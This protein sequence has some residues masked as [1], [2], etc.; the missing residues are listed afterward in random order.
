MWDL[1]KIRS[2]YFYILCIV[3][4]KVSA[5]SFLSFSVSFF[6]FSSQSCVADNISKMG[7][8]SYFKTSTKVAAETRE[9]QSIEVTN[10]NSGVL[11]NSATTSILNDKFDNA[12]RVDD[13][14]HQVILN[15][16]WQKQQGLMWV[17][18]V[19]GILEG[20][21]VRKNRTEYI[22]KPSLLSESEFGKAMATLNVQVRL[23]SS[24]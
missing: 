15:Y 4:I 23:R 18:D 11:V 24:Y 5:S 14:R 6:P 8:L 2:L 20:V 3:P 19:T 16:L 13:I 22:C 7:L 17:T 12:Q 1:T 10:N 21:M 9:K